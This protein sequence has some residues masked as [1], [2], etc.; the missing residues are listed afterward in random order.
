MSFAPIFL[1]LSLWGQKPSVL[2]EWISTEI[3]EK[4]FIPEKLSKK[5]IKNGRITVVLD[6]LDE[7]S[8]KL[9]DTCIIAI[10]HFIM[11]FPYVQ[12]VVSSRTQDYIALKERL[13][14]QD[15]VSIRPV[16]SWR[17]KKYLK[18]FGDPM[19][20]VLAAME[21]DLHIKSMMKTPLMLSI[22]VIAYKNFSEKEIVEV[23]LKSR[24]NHLFQT[25][26]ERVLKRPRN[27]RIYE[28]PLFYKWIKFLAV[29]MSKKKASIFYIENID[30]SWLSS[31]KQETAYKNLWR[32]FFAIFG[33]L[34]VSFLK[35]YY[36]P[37]AMLTLDE[38]YGSISLSEFEFKKLFRLG[39]VG[40]IFGT[41]IIL[42]PIFLIRSLAGISLELL[43]ELSLLYLTTFALGAFHL[44]ISFLAIGSVLSAMN[45]FFVLP[46][47]KD[48]PNQF[49]WATLQRAMLLGSIN[50]VIL[51]MVAFPIA[52][53]ISRE[54]STATVAMFYLFLYGMS[55][56][57]VSPFGAFCLKHWFVRRVLIKAGLIPV[58][59]RSFLDWCRDILI[60]GRANGGYFFVHR[61][62]LEYIASDDFAIP[63]HKT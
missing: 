3:H 14:I 6:G 62:L 52:L 37:A 59:Y 13:C 4:Y 29:N 40:L 45:Q 16:P 33:L 50:G 55:M 12:V 8:D 39:F 11:K 35:A 34:S 41:F 49:T 24:R 38:A 1:N 10:N 22:A 51:G 25:Y 47:K 60:L 19:S 56:G 20:G 42:L 15:I 28:D 9:R 36:M 63:S 57:I 17:A 18:A 31:K 43:T 2:E 61:L 46:E 58:N 21:S 26:I 27:L 48:V 30:T 32:L 44:G 23:P 7:V 53:A 5:W 54:V